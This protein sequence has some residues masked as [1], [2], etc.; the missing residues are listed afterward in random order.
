MKNQV[1]ACPALGDM[2]PKSKQMNQ[3][4]YSQVCIISKGLS[5]R[6]FLKLRFLSVYFR[7]Y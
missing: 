3:I 2:F 6:Y 7:F 5:I 4:N 1:Q